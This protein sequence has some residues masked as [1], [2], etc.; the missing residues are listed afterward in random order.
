MNK[1]AR[2]MLFSRSGHDDKG[3]D[4]DRRYDIKTYNGGNYDGSRGGQG[5]DGRG[6]TRMDSNRDMDYRHDG[7]YRDDDNRMWYDP[8]RH[9][10]GIRWDNR[11]YMPEI[12]NA[13]YDRRGRRHYDD[14]RYAPQSMLQDPKYSEYPYISPY[15]PQS[16][17][18]VNDDYRTSNIGFNA[19]RGMYDFEMDGRAGD[20]MGYA[21]GHIMPAKMRH[22]KMM[23]DEP[24]ELDE[25]T[26]K[27][28]V[29]SM[30]NADGTKG[31]HW[32]QKQTDEIM[33][34]LGLDC[35]SLEFWVAMCAV[36]SDFCEVFK[37]LGIDKP[38][39]YA[40]FAEAF[41][42]EDE[43]AKDNK[44]ARYYEYIVK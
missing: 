44:L 34:K 37:Q 14:G 40:E 26:A 15:M 16:R 12:E 35:D 21:K 42:F 17:R 41:W 24:E 13:F 8:A 23:Q 9:G 43:D 4:W 29:K 5:R 38:E 3:H 20:M 30:E 39:N 31:G 2:M 22:D 33:E 10:S 36:Y 7:G 19:N 25:K 11:E 1:A 18:D 27:K 28:W 6:T 32:T